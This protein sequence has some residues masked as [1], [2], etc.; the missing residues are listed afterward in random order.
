MVSAAERGPG[1]PPHL[2]FFP[3]GFVG[4]RQ[5]AGPWVCAR[6]GGRS[7]WWPRSLL[8][9]RFSGRVGC[10]GGV[11]GGREEVGLGSEGARTGQA[12]HLL[13]VPR[14]LPAPASTLM[15]VLFVPVVFLC[16]GN[17]SL[18]FP[19]F[20]TTWTSVSLSN[21]IRPVILIRDEIKVFSPFFQDY[22]DLSQPL[23]QYSPSYPD[24]RSSCSSGDDSVFSPDPMPYEP[25][26]PPYPQRN[27]SVNT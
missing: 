1:H 23:E 13:G 24:T 19:S 26:L 6:R 17:K 12:L 16:V 11:P 15:P 10:R 2:R 4:Q 8:A 25:C 22:L 21:R 18:L 27:G 3:I 5:P 7:A 9:P 14:P 20:R